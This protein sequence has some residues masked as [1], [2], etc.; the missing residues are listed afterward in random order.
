[1]SGS[2]RI[3]IVFTFFI[4]LCSSMHWSSHVQG[5]KHPTTLRNDCNFNGK[6]LSMVDKYGDSAGIGGVIFLYRCKIWTQHVKCGLMQGDKTFKIK[7]EKWNLKFKV[8]ILFLLFQQNTKTFFAFPQKAK[9]QNLQPARFRAVNSKKLLGVIFLQQSTHAFVLCM[10]V[11]LRLPPKQLS[12]SCRCSMCPPLKESFHQNWKL[13]RSCGWKDN[14][15]KSC[16]LELYYRYS[17]ACRHQ[18]NKIV[19][20]A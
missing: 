5:C 11:T 12:K 6:F 13:R 3:K 16:N 4:L 19:F 8:N 15:L 7:R 18:S 9:T 20:L 17:W 10:M 1:M 2:K 14:I